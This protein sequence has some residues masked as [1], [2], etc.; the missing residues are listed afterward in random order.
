MINR[1]LIS[2]MFSFNNF[3]IEWIQTDLEVWNIN[4]NST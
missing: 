1:N 3:A 4:E 2:S